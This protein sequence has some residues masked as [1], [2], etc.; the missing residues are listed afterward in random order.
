MGKSIPG[1]HDLKCSQEWV[2]K[3]K[4]K[5]VLDLDSDRTG[6]ESSLI[7]PSTRKTGSQG[8][9]NCHIV[10]ARKEVWNTWATGDD[11]HVIIWP[12]P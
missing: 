5:Y 6:L 2:S 8:I 12:L 11:S 10:K 7:E 1:V 3:E 9:F 4:A